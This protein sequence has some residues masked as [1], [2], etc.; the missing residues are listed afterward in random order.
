MTSAALRPKDLLGQEAWAELTAPV[1]WQGYAL[2]A[3]AWLVIGVA[4]AAVQLSG[5]HPLVVI[6]AIMVVGNRQ[7][8]LAILMHEA[9]HGLLSRDQKVNDFMGQWLC[10][11]PVGADLH[12]YRPYHLSH[13]RHV[14]SEA[15]PDLPLAAPFPVSPSSLRRKIFRDL[16][17]QTFVKQRIFAVRAFF[18]PALV[19]QPGAETIANRRAVG[20]FFAIN[21][22]GLIIFTAM[23]LGL[24]FLVCWLVPLA[25]W[26]PLATRIRN[27]AEHACVNGDSD[28]PLTQARTTRASFLERILIAPY[29]VS[30]HAEH[31]A[32]MFVP[33]FRLPRAHRLLRERDALGHTDVAP[34]YLA[35]LRR[36]TERAANNVHT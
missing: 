36:V 8:G 28:N 6:G 7:L 21:G 1:I 30:Y 5:Y 11:A 2:V 33:C 23:G 16:T 22:A 17:G 34:S 18:D 26:N 14:Q 24:L 4:M 19:Q 10:A 29:W 32:M 9:A 35:V 25:T 3:H 15:D 27:I 13:H 20:R 31:H 12:A